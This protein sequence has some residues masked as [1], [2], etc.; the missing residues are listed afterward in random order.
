MNQ[1]QETTRPE[2]VSTPGQYTSI[3]LKLTLISV[4]MLLFGFIIYS[5]ISVRIGQGSLLN[6]VKENMQKSTND[7]ASL[8]KKGYLKPV[9]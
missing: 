3:G 2:K 8:N 4:G 1:H 6:N 5:I 9:L 7:G